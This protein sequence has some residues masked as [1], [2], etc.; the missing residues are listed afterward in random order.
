[1][2]KIMVLDRSTP[3]S[4]F[5]EI[6]RIHLASIHHGALPLLGSPFMARM[7]FEIARAPK[8]GIWVAWKDDAL[9]GFVAGCADLSG[10]FRSVL[11]RGGFS[12]GVKALPKLF[13]FSALRRLPTLLAYPFR[14]NPDSS[15]RNDFA[16]VR[17]ELLAIAVKEG[18]RELGAGRLLVEAFEKALREWDVHI[19]R[20]ST[21]TTET[22]SNRFY[23]RMGFK[24]AGTQQ[25]HAL[26]LQLYVKQL[27]P[28]ETF[29]DVS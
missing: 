6:T 19:Y 25:H 23:S 18:M 17:S 4:T 12:L 1:M 13:S 3:Y 2:L 29:S 10:C 9:V 7:Y 15:K 21:N 24:P 14:T 28:T 16:A 8:A 20:V 27:D 22:A 5:V 11:C 26:K